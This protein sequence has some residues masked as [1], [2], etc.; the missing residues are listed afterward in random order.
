MGVALFL[1]GLTVGFLTLRYPID[2]LLSFGAQYFAEL[3]TADNYFIFVSYFLLAFGLAFELPLVLTF[4]AVM[5]VVSSQQLRKNR[6]AILVGLWIA[7]CFITPGA[8]PYSPLILGVAF[9]VLYFLSEGLIRA[10]AS[11]QTIEDGGD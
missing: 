5:G 4:L 3:I 7:S 1:A 8:D 10:L 6:A 11:I 9:T 2:W